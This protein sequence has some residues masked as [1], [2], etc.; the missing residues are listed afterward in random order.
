MKK[1]LSFLLVFIFL[2]NYLS[3]ISAS[4]YDS[5]DKAT[6]VTRNEFMKTNLEQS[7]VSGLQNL[8]QSASNDAEATAVYNE[9]KDRIDNSQVQSSIMIDTYFTH[10]STIVNKTSITVHYRI[11]ALVPSGAFLYLGYEYPAITRT[12]GSF[13]SLNGKAV[14]SY[15]ASF[16]SKGLISQSRTYASFSAHS[17]SE[18]KTF[19]PYLAFNTSSN[20][21]HHL[22]TPSEIVAG[23]IALTIATV[24]TFIVLAKLKLL[25]VAGIVLGVDITGIWASPPELEAYNY[26]EIFT[27]YSGVRMYRTIKIW[28]NY[29]SF[30][31]AY[32]FPAYY[33]S[34]SASLP[35]F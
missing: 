14:G 16:T 9:L 15:Q 31:N 34:S 21:T 20:L 27:Y 11:N 28:S 18:K 35:G 32:N 2:V 13:I 33:G 4:T 25:W 12:S 17:Y 30:I 6:Q 10:T 24:S 5:M 29:G 26:I 19:S 22:V 8:A 23:K 1:I 7:S 3:P